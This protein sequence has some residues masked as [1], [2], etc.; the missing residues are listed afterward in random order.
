MQTSCVLCVAAPW[1]R[2]ERLLREMPRG[3]WDLQTWKLVKPEIRK[4]L[5]EWRR[6]ERAAWFN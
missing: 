5:D 2:V 6:I 4:A 1:L 3:R